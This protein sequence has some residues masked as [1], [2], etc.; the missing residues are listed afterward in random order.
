[1]PPLSNK[2]S[3]ALQGFLLELSQLTQKF[4]FSVHGPVEHDGWTRNPEI[5]G[6]G[7]WLELIYDETRQ[8]YDAV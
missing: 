6:N 5:R 2:K 1:M 4:G 7:E 8:E 3:P